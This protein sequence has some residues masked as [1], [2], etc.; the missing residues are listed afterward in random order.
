M[1][2][3]FLPKMVKLENL[4]FYIKFWLDLIMQIFC[5]KLLNIKNCLKTPSYK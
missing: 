2:L 1:K 4:T 3:V 5:V